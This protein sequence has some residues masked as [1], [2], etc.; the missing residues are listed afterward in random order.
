MTERNSPEP[1][2]RPPEVRR[3]IGV[4]L[5]IDAVIIDTQVQVAPGGVWSSDCAVTFRQGIG[6]LGLEHGR[7]QIEKVVE[8]EMEDATCWRV[9]TRSF[10]H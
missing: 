10:W 4:P 9:W 7:I 2:S 3:R 1:C 6:A 8:L 5:S